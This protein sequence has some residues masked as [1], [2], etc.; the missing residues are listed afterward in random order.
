M[1]YHECSIAGTKLQRT[2]GAK[3]DCYL[4]VIKF[5]EGLNVIQ[6]PIEVIPST[7][8]K[9]LD[10][11]IYNNTMLRF[12]LK[13]FTTHNQFFL[14]WKMLVLLI[15]VVGAQSENFT[16][17]LYPCLKPNESMLNRTDLKGMPFELKRTLTEE[18]S[19][20][21]RYIVPIP[22]A[23]DLCDYIQKKVIVI[24]RRIYGIAA[25][26]QNG[27]AENVSDTT[28]KRSEV[29]SYLA[30][31]YLIS[32][33][34]VIRQNYCKNK[35]K[36]FSEESFE[37]ITVQPKSEDVISEGGTSMGLRVV[38]VVCNIA[39]IIGQLL[40]L[41]LCWKATNLQAIY[42]QRCLMF[43]AV[44]QGL[45]HVL[46]LASLHLYN[47]VHACMVISISSHWM[48]LCAFVW[49]SCASYEINWILSEKC[50]FTKQE[51]YTGY[52][53]FAFGL[54][55]VIVLSCTIIHFSS[56]KSIGYGQEHS[57]FIGN[58]WSNFYSFLLPT[59]IAFL[60]S[61]IWT[62]YNYKLHVTSTKSN[63]FRKGEA[64]SLIRS[65]FSIILR[66]TL[67]LFAFLASRYIDVFLKASWA[68][69]AIANV[70]IS[71]QGTA[72]FF[73]MVTSRDVLSAVKSACCRK[74][75]DRV[76]Y[77]YKYRKRATFQNNA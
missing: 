69:A 34:V 56:E 37:C 20:I 18:V 12:D 76:T 26:I 32:K 48:A 30:A 42:P 75:N 31:E 27:L 43:L 22:S 28:S 49:L 63:R 55:A 60:L 6:H 9:V 64:Y 68:A 13:M 21:E 29:L 74:Q 3:E 57:C 62:V 53:C 73:G 8:S 33:V 17:A 14:H 61:A 50:S 54:T 59:S 35:E 4:I 65:R 71:L 1:E 11:K 58:K 36:H 66:I 45:L 38:L 19:K 25:E 40:L 2:Q 52:I 23:A 24:F 15:M 44:T 46:Q 72:I 16:R 67:V 10:V 5:T 51:R 70:L 77:A 47:F 7:C 41:I 39:S